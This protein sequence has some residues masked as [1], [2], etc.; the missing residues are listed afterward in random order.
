MII[1]ILIDNISVSQILFYGHTGGHNTRS[2]LHSFLLIF[3]QTESQ[4][5]MEERIFKG[6][7][8]YLSPGE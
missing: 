8:N 2:R 6:M 1:D 3:C 5:A 7:V 4:F